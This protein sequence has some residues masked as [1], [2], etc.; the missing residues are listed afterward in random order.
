MS[1]KILIVDDSMTALLMQ[2]AVFSRYPQYNLVT[3]RDG[4]EA[5]QQALQER[6]DLILMDVIM[7]NMDGFSACREMRKR[8]E[9]RRI[10]IIL[11]T[12]RGEA[13]NVEEGFASGC[14][15]YLTKPIVEKELLRMVNTYLT[16]ANAEQG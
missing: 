6:P 10:P 3:A 5:I 2:Q 14:S 15:D 4:R 13:C 7:P 9:L 11:V 8:E 12:S 1:Q 16:P